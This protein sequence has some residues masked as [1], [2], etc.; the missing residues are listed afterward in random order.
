MSK[1]QFSPSLQ[2]ILLEAVI[3]CALAVTVGLSLNY[4]MVMNAFT[5]KTVAA[6]KTAQQGNGTGETSAGMQT[7][8]FPDPVELDELDGLLASGALLVDARNSEAYAEQHLPGAVSLPL[9]E[10]DSRLSEFLTKVP[11]D[12]LLIT[13]CNGFGCPDSFDLG[14]R[15]LKEGYRQVLV[16]EG[17]FPQWRDAGRPLE[18][19]R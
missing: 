1:L 17:G 8:Q 12:R 16:F 13:Y 4:R 19:G 10:V 3:L 11:K 14:V 9:G 18:G 7:Q 5:G 15:L 2:R 6:P